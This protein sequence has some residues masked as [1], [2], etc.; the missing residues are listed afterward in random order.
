MFFD[1]TLS[2]RHV[3][4][5]GDEHTLRCK[6][7]GNG[8]PKPERVSPHDEDICHR[9]LCLDETATDIFPIVKVI[10]RR[11]LVGPESYTGPRVGMNYR[12]NAALYD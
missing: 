6:S 3:G 11:S 4:P 2:M 9:Q 7:R 10:Q 8:D 1:S 12:K 5:C